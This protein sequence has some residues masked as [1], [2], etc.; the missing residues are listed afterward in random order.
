MQSLSGLIVRVERAQQPDRRL[1][2]EV[3]AAVLGPPGCHV[4]RWGEEFDI[5]TTPDEE[6]ENETWR[7]ADEI[8]RVTG[9][10]EDALSFV[11]QARSADAVQIAA[12]AF[13][14][15]GSIPELD[16]RAW[17]SKVARSVVAAT[18]RVVTRERGG[19]NTT[20]SLADVA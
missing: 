14:D 15:S 6:G 4:V 8:G 18:L 5:E 13:R 7:N 12:C 16:L 20:S 2:A 10:L 3:V 9:S 17:T 19:E 11:T 1:D